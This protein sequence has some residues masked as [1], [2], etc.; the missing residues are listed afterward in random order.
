MSINLPPPYR[1]SGT[2]TCLIDEETEVRKSH[3][4][5][6]PADL[7]LTGLS[8]GSATGRDTVPGTEKM[9][10]EWEALL[11]PS[12]PQCSA[13]SSVVA[14]E[15]CA[16]HQLRPLL[17]TFQTIHLSFSRSPT[18]PHNY[19]SPAAALEALL[20]DR[21][22]GPGQEASSGA[23]EPNPRGPRQ[24]QLAVYFSGCASSPPFS[25]AAPPLPCWFISNGFHPVL[26][27]LSELMPAIENSLSESEMLGFCGYTEP[28]GT[29][30][31]PS[32]N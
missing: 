16:H 14:E 28:R 15:A 8:P 3:P 13:V 7:G 26:F 22:S 18:Q 19:L 24:A 17:Q 5:H 6:P 4:R 1:K 20:P 27:C 9:P 32:C 25:G 2:Y 10:S 30:Q 31:L 21:P 23:K 29:K 11:Y 12:P